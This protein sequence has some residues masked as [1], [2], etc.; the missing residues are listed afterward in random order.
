MSTVPLLRQLRRRLQQLLHRRGQTRE[1]AEDVIQD[2]FLRLQIYYQQGG[3]VREPE[4]FLVRTALRLSMNARRDARRHLYVE[5]SPE[6]LP[7]IDTSPA[8]E[9]VFAAEQ[10][11][12]RMKQT[13]NLVSPRT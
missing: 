12:R 3:E 4:A 6:S 8:P 9:D 7:L 2:A 1:D 11:L 13:L 10:R 5:D